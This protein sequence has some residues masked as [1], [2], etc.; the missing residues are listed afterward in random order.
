MLWL[1]WRQHRTQVLVTA[2]FL[3]G[4]GVVLLVHGLSAV[5]AAGG[6]EHARCSEAA[7]C[8]QVDAVLTERYDQL[9]QFLRPVPLLPAFVGVFW[10]APILAREFEHGTHKLAWTQ[11]VPRWRWV[12]VKL[13][14][15]GTLVALG[16][17]VTGLMIRAWQG[18]FGA[19]AKAF[20]DRAMF[21]VVGVAPV[22]WWLFMFVLGV[23]AGALV[24][25]LLPAIAVTFAMFVVVYGGLYILRADYAEPEHH[26]ASTSDNSG[27][28][29]AMLLEAGIQAPDGTRLG[30]SAAGQ[31]CPGPPAA[32][33]LCLRAGGYR[34]FVDYQPADRF[35]RFQWTEA[36]ILGA[37]TLLFGALAVYGTVRRRV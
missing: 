34:N 37:G 11:S 3:L 18:V 5:S 35:W 9:Y 30:L 17:L 16:G 8:M 31:V 33:V 23:A 28:G 21:T 14:V 19:A 25:R 7:G 10:G 26:V 29:D 4:L 20:G 1:T 36:G 24:R 13:G 2:A 22:A 6:E 32:R 15:L 27:L 12:A